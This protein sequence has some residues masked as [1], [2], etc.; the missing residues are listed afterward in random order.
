VRRRVARRRLAGASV[1]IAVAAAVAVAFAHSSANRVTVAHSVKDVEL[2]QLQRFDAAVVL[3]DGATDK[4][5]A[6]VEQLLDDSTAILRYA[7][8]PARNLAYA[9]SFNAD[10][11]VKAL[12]ARVCAAPATKSFAVQLSRDNADAKQHLADALGADAT[13]QTMGAHAAVDAEV[14]MQVKATAAQVD[15]VRERLGSDP[16][17]AS[18]Q[19]LSHDDAY[20]E[21]KRLF[22][23]QPKLVQS[24][25][26]AS[27]PESFRI[28]LR[29][30]AT[31]AGVEQRV[32]TLS[33]VDQV[34][35]SATYN[36]A[37]DP[38]LTFD[39]IC[40]SKSLFP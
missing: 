36:P 16:D 2:S 5:R 9:L 32:R 25:S 6:R 8:L 31:P 18:F 13:V 3:P 29:E 21:F 40:S 34:N 11:D 26:P 33:G 23:D 14:F 24:E 4:D 19:Y 30:N 12:R 7:P 10:A 39:D 15:A 20:D 27:L 35:T 38:T 22:A 37:P 17:V 28:T 1:A